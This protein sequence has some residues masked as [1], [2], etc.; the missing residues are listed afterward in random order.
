MEGIELSIETG[1]IDFAFVNSP[2]RIALY[3]DMLSSPRIIDVK[4]AETGEFIGKLSAEI[5]NQAQQLGGSIPYTIISQVAENFIHA[6]FKEM[7]VSIFDSG[8]T[9]RFTD[10]GPG[11]ADKLKAQQPGYSSATRE[12]KAYINGVGSGLPIVREYLDTKH[13]TIHIEDNMNSG[14]VVTISLV[15]KESAEG[16]AG[17]TPTISSATQIQQTPNL[18]NSMYSQS[19]QSI[20]NAQFMQAQ[21]FENLVQPFADGMIITEQQTFQQP[22]QQ[23]TQPYINPVDSQR[24]LQLILSSLSKREI[25]IIYLFKNN[26]VWGITDISKETGIPASST[27]NL[28]SK[29]E[30]MGIL[31]KVGKKRALSDLGEHIL[32]FL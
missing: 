9:I 6:S 3:D 4:P 22:T 10:Q 20:Y 18:Q 26:D 24:S 13:G 8:N 31:I 14:A 19:Q 11:I 5:Y 15:D 23:S 32:N 1:N 27:S 30:Q 7:V 17:E 28:L 2:A 16:P 12:M 29:L 25:S 21:Q